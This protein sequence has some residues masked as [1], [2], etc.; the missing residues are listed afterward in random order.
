MHGLLKW[1][2]FGPDAQTTSQPRAN[3]R[4]LGPAA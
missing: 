2:R 4:V 1:F 3:K